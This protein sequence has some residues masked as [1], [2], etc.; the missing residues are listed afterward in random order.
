MRGH[1][2]EENGCAGS[3]KLQQRPSLHNPNIYSCGISS[4]S[5]SYLSCEKECLYA[6]CLFL[7]L[8]KWT[9]AFIDHLIFLIPFAYKYPLSQGIHF[10]VTCDIPRAQGAPW[11]PW[12]L[13]RQWE[14]KWSSSA[15]LRTAH[16]TLTEICTIGNM[17]SCCIGGVHGP[18]YI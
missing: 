1:C 9:D 6:F 10:D 3:A 18:E 15:A 7:H 16:L 14:T 17:S 4:F 11:I 5:W 8:T 13:W 2:W 12:W